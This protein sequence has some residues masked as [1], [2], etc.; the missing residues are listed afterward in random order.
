MERD[1]IGD[2][3]MDTYGTAAFI[4]PLQNSARCTAT[5]IEPLKPDHAG[6]S[7]APS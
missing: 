7:E 6:G 1:K 2:I 3:L 4:Y 5:G